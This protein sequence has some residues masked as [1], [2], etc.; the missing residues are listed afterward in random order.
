MEGYCMPT[1]TIFDGFEELSE[2]ERQIAQFERSWSDFAYYILTQLRFRRNEAGAVT[3]IH[4]HG[5]TGLRAQFDAYRDYGLSIGFKMVFS[6]PFVRS[7]YMADMVS[8]HALQT[9]C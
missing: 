8:E 9:E 6:G 2:V 4:C 1:E 3:K 5:F 7:S